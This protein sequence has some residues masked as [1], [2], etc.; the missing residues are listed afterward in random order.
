MFK[1]MFDE[2]HVDEKW[3]DLTF[4]G[5]RVI[6]MEGEAPVKRSTRHKS[7]VQKVM[8]L[9]AQARPRDR[10][11]GKLGIWPIGRWVKAQKNSC[12]R[13]AGTMEWKNISLAHG[14]TPMTH[15]YVQA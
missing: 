15:L 6:L 9:C 14:A 10:W 1:N 3:F 13:L 4:D 8:F 7:Y 2:V 12:N 5:R 11:D